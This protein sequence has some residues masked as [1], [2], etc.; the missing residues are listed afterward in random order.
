MTTPFYE[1][2]LNVLTVFAL[3]APL[4]YLLT[5]FALGHRV[6]QESKDREWK[7]LACQMALYELQ[8]VESINAMRRALHQDPIQHQ[9]LLHRPE[10]CSRLWT[11][12]RH[13]AK[14]STTLTVD[15]LMNVV[16]RA[17]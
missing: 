14:T 4:I 7:M 12:L 3:I 6:I 16:G 11:I 15:R 9:P 10:F 5:D 1:I 17:T 8:V 13:K 2:A